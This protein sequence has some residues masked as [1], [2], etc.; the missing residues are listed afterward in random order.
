MI[1]ECD[2]RYKKA[3]ELFALPLLRFCVSLVFFEILSLRRSAPFQNDRGV[4][5]PVFEILSVA[6]APSRT[7]EGSRV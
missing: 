2:W 3:E 4:K 5:K 1:V 7:T 6:N